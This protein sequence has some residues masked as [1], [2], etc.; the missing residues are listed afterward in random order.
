MFGSSILVHEQV[1]NRIG[2]LG[3]LATETYEI[4]VL[5]AAL[6]AGVWFGN[7]Q[8][9]SWILYS[10][11][12]FIS[13]TVF[14]LA[15]SLWYSHGRLIHTT[16]EEADL[17]LPFARPVRG[18]LGR[19][20][21]EVWDWFGTRLSY[22]FSSSIL[23]NCVMLSMVSSCFEVRSSPLW[24]WSKVWPI[25]CASRVEVHSAVSIFYDWFSPRF[26]SPMF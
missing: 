8:L 4:G 5:I 24:F 25:P 14:T 12:L 18:G 13:G 6:I 20:L 19:G 23:T 3:D 7:Y 2:T 1:L 26:C 17:K 21:G 10:A 16:P 15:V 11:V 22:F 9:V